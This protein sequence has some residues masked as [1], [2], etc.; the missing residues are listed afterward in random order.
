MRKNRSAS[1]RLA[2]AMSVA[3]CVLVLGLVFHAVWE[4]PSFEAA[5]QARCAEFLVPVVP[6][7]ERALA[8]R[9]GASRLVHWKDTHSGDVI[10]TFRKGEQAVK[11]TVLEQR[12]QIFLLGAKRGLIVPRVTV[13]RRGLS[14]L[15]GLPC[16]L[17]VIVSEL[18]LGRRQKATAGRYGS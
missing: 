9:F 16:C 2:L 8:R 13:H 4:A 15:L 6:A 10:T 11:C 3:W 12:A 7:L 5:A 18:M 1:L 17:F 14:L